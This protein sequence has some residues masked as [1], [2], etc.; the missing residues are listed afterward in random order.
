MTLNR[1][2]LWLGVTLVVAALLVLVLVMQ[3]FARPELYQN[4]LQASRDTI[5]STTY[6]IEI[7]LKEAE[8]LTQSI[9]SQAAS[10]PL[11]RETW[12]QQLAP[13]IDNFGNAAIAGGGVWPEPNRFSPGTERASFFW[14]RNNSG[15]LELLNDYNDPAGTGYHN[16]SWYQ[17]GRTLNAGQCGWSESYEDPVSGTPMVTCTVPVQR[18]NQFWGVAT[19][20]LMLSGLNKMLETRNTTTGGYNLVLDQTGRIVSFPGIRS[21]SLN[22]STLDDAIQR[23]PGLAPLKTAINQDESTQELPASVVGH[24]QSVLLKTTM[25]EQGWTVAMI[26]PHKRA[27]AAVNSITKGLFFVM[28]PLVMIFAAA[29]IL[30]GRRIISSLNATTDQVNKLAQGHIDDKL[31]VVR[32]D[33]IGQLQQA[34][35][36]YG[37]HL[38]TILH[39]IVNEATTLGDDA[40]GLGQLSTQLS[41][42]AVQQMGENETLAAA[43]NEMSA[44][45]NEIS[46]NTG[47]TAEA[48]EQASALVDQGRQSV[49]Q[50]SQAIEQLDN[51]L[52][53]ARQ[54]I[55]QLSDDA[56]QASS[57]LEVIKTISEQ[58]NLLALNAAIE[59]ARAGEAGRGFAVV[60]DEVRSLA[61]KT[62][63]SASEIDGIIN[64]LQS[65]A[66]Q[67]VEAIEESHSASQS[68]LDQA[69]QTQQIF[70]DIVP[71]FDHIR[72]NTM[73][74]S[75][76]TQQQSNVAEDI[77]QMAERIYHLAEANGQDANHLSTMSQNTIA[78]AERLK[79]LGSQ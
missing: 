24:D 25:P 11:N 10:L 37:E 57:I 5:E 23:Y 21:D 56:Q 67:A 61:S 70:N 66:H 39:Q 33:E 19:V 75:S 1:K 7:A 9:A 47:T 63:E 52:Q 76:A 45:A 29:L 65:G 79:A 26:L 8:A 78:A 51:R 62:Q 41:D 16:E 55:D 34:V 22:M 36:H 31:K 59:A 17:V 28:T 46:D 35:N 49:D 72:N 15:Q 14:A 53:S 32:N 42:R 43:I 4:Q 2:I 48:A 20:D 38:A 44:S 27:M 50:N 3:M 74:I 54:V 13:L 64:K 68:S 58:T 30:F 77:S 6:Q 60:A 71:A 73:S 12:R 69:Q 18:N 40:K